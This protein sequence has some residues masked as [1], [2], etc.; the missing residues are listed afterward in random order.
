MGSMVSVYVII[1]C[2]QIFVSF[3]WLKPCY[4]IF[5]NPDHFP[6]KRN[7]RAIVPFY[8]RFLPCDL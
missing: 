7:D 4:M 3:H 2:I 6:E 1:C 8:W 5:V